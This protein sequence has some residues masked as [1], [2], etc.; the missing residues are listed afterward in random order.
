MLNKP[1]KPP[2]PFPWKCHNCF[3]TEVVPKTV[4]YDADF[5]HDG[6]LHKF[7]VPA[8]RIPICEACGEKVF[9]EQ[10]GDQITDALRAHLHLLTPLEIRAGLERLNIATAEAAER[11][12][13]S[14]E[15]LSA[16]LD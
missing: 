9:T 14:E 15:E 4:S 13:I 2:T 1:P 3:K 6:R 7:T 16:W 11:L 5:R 8:L 12:G 10:V